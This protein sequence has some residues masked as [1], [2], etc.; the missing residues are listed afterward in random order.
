MRQTVSYVYGLSPVLMSGYVY[1]LSP[2][3]MSADCDSVCRQP[4]FYPLGDKFDRQSAISMDFQPV[5]MFMDFSPVGMYLWTVYVSVDNQTVL[6][7]ADSLT[8][9]LSADSLTVWLSID[10]LVVTS[11]LQ[12]S[13]SQY[14]YGYFA[15]RGVYRHSDCSGMMS[16]DNRR[17]SLSVDSLTTYL[18]FVGQRRS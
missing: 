5:R 17:I 3:L 1:G 13:E 12:F 7:S 6:L 18:R 11:E 2:V 8:V 10:I 16:V 9:L 15:V 4:V 14:F